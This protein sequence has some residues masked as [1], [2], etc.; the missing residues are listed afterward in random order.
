MRDS[1]SLSTQPKPSL[2]H[3]SG[4]F[5]VLDFLPSKR[6][7]WAYY[8]SFYASNTVIPAYHIIIISTR[9]RATLFHSSVKEE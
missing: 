6:I 8:R 1:V 2:F 9:K 7:K 4:G 5:V 3:P